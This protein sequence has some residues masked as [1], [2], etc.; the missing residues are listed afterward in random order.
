MLE[1]IQVRKATYPCRK[2]VTNFFVHYQI[3]HPDFE[4]RKADSQLQAKQLCKELI[5]KVFPKHTEKEYLIGISKVYLKQEAEL[6]WDLKKNEVI[7]QK[8]VKVAIKM[9]AVFKGYKV[10]KWY[11]RK[12]LGAKHIADFLGKKKCEIL[13]SSW[14]KSRKYSA[15]QWFS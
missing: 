15:I 8:M 13:Q 14:K 2:L 11:K 9:I 10:R 3:C 6:A 7:K 4:K 5:Q 1:S 12:R